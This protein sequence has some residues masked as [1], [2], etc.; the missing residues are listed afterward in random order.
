LMLVTAGLTALF[1]PRMGLLIQTLGERKTIAMENAILIVVFAG[2]ALTSSATVA[3]LLFMIDAAFFTLLLAQRTYFQKIGSPEDM[4]PT[5]AVAF[6]INHIAAVALPV[7]FGV[8]G[9]FN[10][11]YIFWLGVLIASISFCLS[12]LVPEDPA[13]GHETVFQPRRLQPAE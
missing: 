12:F 8:L 13:E 5:A 3:G 11:T 4:A 10:Y 7:A 9:M 2:Y 6:T 1:A